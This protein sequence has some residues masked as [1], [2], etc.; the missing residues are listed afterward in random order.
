MRLRGGRRASTMTR[1]RGLRI[2]NV[3]TSITLLCAALA[4]ASLAPPPIARAEN[5]PSLLAGNRSI[6]PSFKV[7][8]LE[9]RTLEL[10]ELRSHGP[11]LVDFWATWCKPCVASLPELEDL[12]KRYVARGLTVI[13]VSIDGPRNFAKVRPFVART[14]LT[15]PIVLDEEGDLQEGFRVVAV[16]TSFLIGRDGAITRVQQGYRP[17]ETAALATA[18]ETALGPAVTASGSADSSSADSSATPAP[19]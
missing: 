9:G 8:T 10:N 11:V 14:G 6:A 18:I 3:R 4:G 12:H 2:V 5:A 15:Y 16:P 7:R 1:V 13:G 19:H 17:G